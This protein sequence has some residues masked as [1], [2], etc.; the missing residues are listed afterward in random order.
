[1]LPLF[2]LGGGEAYFL[3]LNPRPGG[4][5]E[6]PVPWA[7]MDDDLAWEELRELAADPVHQAHVRALLDRAE[8][9]ELE[10]V[11]TDADWAALRRR[12]RLD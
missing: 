8:A 1:M 7:P 2:L 10:T 12:L 3:A 4:I 11:S 5:A 9:G 6:G